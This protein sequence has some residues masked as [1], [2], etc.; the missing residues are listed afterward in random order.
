MLTK[1]QAKERAEAE[2]EAKQLE[3]AFD[4][5]WLQRSVSD[6][7]L[8]YLSMQSSV[9]LSEHLDIPKGFAIPGLPTDRQIS[10]DLRAS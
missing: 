6:E 3:G 4:Q 5:P 1:L 2:E 8:S 7:G 10:F 9:I